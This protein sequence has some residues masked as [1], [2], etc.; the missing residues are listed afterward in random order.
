MYFD[1]LALKLLAD[2]IVMVL[3]CVLAHKGSHF[4]GLAQTNGEKNPK[5]S[6]LAV[7]N[8]QQ[9]SCLCEMRGENVTPI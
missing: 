2:T 8:A 6:P 1:W 5:N 9:G 4:L 3:I 7:H